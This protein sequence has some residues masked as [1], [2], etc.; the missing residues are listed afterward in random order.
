VQRD[1]A[2]KAQQE[3]RR[4]EDALAQAIGSRV[5]KAIGDA[6]PVR[7]MKRDLL[8]L[9]ERLAVMLDERRLSVLI[10][11]NRIGKPKDGDAPARVI[12]AFL[13]KADECQIGRMLVQSVILSSI[14]SDNDG[15]RVL[16]DAAQAYKVDV[17]VISKNARKE[18]AEK[19]KTKKADKPTQKPSIKPPTKSRKQ[20]GTA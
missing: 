18:F 19:E 5:L 20:R 15:M 10:R 1:V 7:L 16:K 17:D 12:L 4:R 3:Q 13:Q 14:R 11:Q 6:V 8:F 9:T 2:F